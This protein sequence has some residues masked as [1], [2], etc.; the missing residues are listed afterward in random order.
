MQ[1]DFAEGEVQTW[2]LTPDRSDL[3]EYIIATLPFAAAN[4]VLRPEMFDAT[5]GRGE[6]RPVAK[7]HVNKLRAAMLAGRYTPTTAGATVPASLRPL[8]VRTGNRVSVPLDEGHPLLLTDFGHRMA[9]LR[10]IRE[11]EPSLASLVDAVP[12]TTLIYLDGD[13]QSDFI[14]LQAGKPVD[15]NHLASLRASR[16]EIGADEAKALAIAK[17]LNTNTRSPFYSHIRFPGRTSVASLPYKSIAEKGGSALATS[18]VGLAKVAPP[19]WGVDETVSFFIDVCAV[20][21]S[22]VPHLTEYGQ[23]LAAPPDMNVA[24]ATLTIGVATLVAFRLYK[25]EAALES[26]EAERIARSASEVFAVQDYS[27]AQAK[28]SLMGRFASHYLSDIGDNREGIPISLIA[29]LKPSAFNL[30]ATR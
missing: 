25:T 6:Q 16:G 14:N 7:P 22:R 23:P 18:L 15:G 5:T 13:P 10:A 9:A 1:T 11:T 29:L 27:S 28:R 3:R 2:T 30:R 20:L 4:R 26:K 17:A 21:R 19:H 12:V 8:V 24:S